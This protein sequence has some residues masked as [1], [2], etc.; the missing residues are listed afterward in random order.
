M[1]AHLVGLR[2]QSPSEELGLGGMDVKTS[3]LQRLRWV[4][5][6]QQ[7]RQQEGCPKEHGSHPCLFVLLLL[8]LTRRS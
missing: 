3:I 5:A 8:L 7:Q 1:D 6:D 2:R 4:E